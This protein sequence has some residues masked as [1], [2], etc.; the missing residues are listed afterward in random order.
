MKAF[1]V[2]SLFA[3]FIAAQSI[4]TYDTSAVICTVANETSA[5]ANFADACC[6][7]AT[8]KNGTATAVSSTRCINRRLTEYAASTW[9]N[10]SSTINIT[11]QYACLN[12]TKPSTYTTYPSCSYSDNCTSGY[13]CANLAYTLNTAVPRTVNVTG[14][15]CVPGSQGKDSG[16]GNAYKLISGVTNADATVTSVCYSSINSS[17]YSSAILLKSAVALAVAGIVSLVL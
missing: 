15:V 13:C 2:A 6:G 16:S 10:Q 11:V 12:T 7:T 14:T 17:F 8:Y 9:W 5:C 1:I 3:G 4:T